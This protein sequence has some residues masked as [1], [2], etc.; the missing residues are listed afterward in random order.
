MHR[1]GYSLVSTLDAY[2]ARSDTFYSIDPDDGSCWLCDKPGPI[3]HI[4]A[5][6]DPVLDVC[7]DCIEQIAQL[8]K[9]G[10]GP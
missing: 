2:K 8:F 4:T 3:I 6:H 5:N 1:I 9:D 7:E 10:V